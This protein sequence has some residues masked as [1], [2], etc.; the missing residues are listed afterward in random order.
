MYY[1]NL[2]K[3]QSVAWCE[4]WK[5]LDSF[6]DLSA[7]DGLAKLEEYLRGKKKSNRDKR[8]VLRTPD[9]GKRFLGTHGL[10]D[11]DD[12]VFEQEDGALEPGYEGRDN[13]H[14]PTG[15][16][17]NIKG[18]RSRL[19]W[20]ESTENGKAGVD[21]N[22]RHDL[23]VGDK[24]NC[25]D[26][27]PN[28]H[29]TEQNGRMVSEKDFS[30]RIDNTISVIENCS[31]SM[32]ILSE[33]ERKNRNEREELVEELHSTCEELPLHGDIVSLNV[34]VS[35][36]DSLLGLP[37]VFEKLSLQGTPSPEMETRIVSSPANGESTPASSGISNATSCT[38]TA[39][40]GEDIPLFIEG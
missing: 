29:L 16:N 9:S 6:C 27:V 40:D 32:P 35:S 10:L 33:E 38:R 3:S 18:F 37:S 20:D 22:E 28:A 1:R 23:L 14:T 7:K 39:S 31:T 8:H 11:G 5:F 25:S 17:R 13:R 15:R 2:A 26:Q 34:S 24:L 21:E 36:E 30:P 4:Y 19:Q 12:F